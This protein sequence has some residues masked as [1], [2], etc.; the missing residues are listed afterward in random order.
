MTSRK[1]RFWRVKLLFYT[2]LSHSIADTNCLKYRIKS[3]LAASPTLLSRPVATHFET[4]RGSSLEV[5]MQNQS[6]QK[7][8]LNGINGSL[9]DPYRSHTSGARSKTRRQLSEY[10]LGTFIAGNWF[11]R[12]WTCQLMLLALIQTPLLC[13]VQTSCIVITESHHFWSGFR[14]DWLD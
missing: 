7:Q 10:S 9:I 11:F 2:A 8:R 3:T 14:S 13:N 6:K 12:K 4:T 5:Y 1:C